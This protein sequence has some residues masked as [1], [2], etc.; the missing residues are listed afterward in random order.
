[1][2]G[3]VAVN[4]WEAFEAVASSTPLAD[5]LVFPDRTLDFASLLRDA[6][7]CA[8]W[9]SAQG[10]RPG[11]VVAIQLPKRCETYPLWLA[12]LRQGAPYV[13]I[14]PRNPVQRTERILDRVQPALLVTELEQPNPHGMSV[15]LPTAGEQDWLETLPAA[16]AA[17]APA[18]V[19]GVDAAY[20]MFTSGSTGEPK[21]AVIHHRGVMNLM[22][23]G[24]THVCAP[25]GGRFSNINPLHFDNSVFDLYC[26]LMNGAAL[27]P[28]ETAG[29]SNPLTW[30]KRLREGRASVVFAVP[31][32]F[33][34]L[35]QLRLLT[36]ASL[37]DVDVFL[38]GG[39]GFPIEAL[40]A[41]HARFSGRSR[42][43]NVYGPTETSCICA[44][45]EIDA[46][47]LDAAGSGLASL[48]RLHADFDH[49]ILDDSGEPADCG[50]L[51]LGGTGVGLGYFANRE[52]TERRFCQDPRQNKYRSIWYR[53]GDLVRQDGSGLL[54]FLGRDDNQVK[55]RGHRI[56]LEEIE[57]TVE[58]MSGVSRAICVAAN[59][60]DGPELR[61]AFA[62]RHAIA[63][64]DVRAFCAGRLPSYMQPVTVV[65]VGQLPQ[66]ANGKVDRRQVRAM[67]GAAT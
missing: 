3:S 12:C 49:L 52:E 24:R 45:L 55:I 8:A 62:A 30:V 29:A 66:N 46:A 39:E 14:D 22:Q 26:G 31:T 65:Q 16:A 48:G 59:G 41:F 67:L 60:A 5:A 58:T 19:Q 2:A 23:W 34:T 35:E 33:L 54:W 18:R 51:W 53:T 57:L 4:L 25:R 13:F 40:R 43:I 6:E 38:F 1:M 21:G 9:L 47:Q 63:V 42:L 37:P 64:E 32:L 36:P 56:E 11:D 10:I 7:R 20:I 28:V 50:E 27:V 44:S 15:V 17:P 61:L